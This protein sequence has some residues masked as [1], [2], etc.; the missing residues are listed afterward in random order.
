MASRLTKKNWI[1]IQIES[2]DSNSKNYRKFQIDIGD[3]IILNQI[4]SGGFG[5]VYAKVLNT[6]N[7]ESQYKKMIN[8]EI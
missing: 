8:R 6:L 3:Y 7:D 2:R 4:E 1:Y 5:L